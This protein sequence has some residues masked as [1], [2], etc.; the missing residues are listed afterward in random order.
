MS[1]AITI[2]LTRHI[3]AEGFGIY[4]YA[5]SVLAIASVPMGR[6][7]GLMIIRNA[8]ASIHTKFWN[9]PIG[10]AKFSKWPA[11]LISFLFIIIAIAIEYKAGFLKSENIAAIVLILLGLVLL[12][13]QMSAIRVALIRSFEKPELAQITDQ[14]AKPF[15]III[16]LIL[17]LNFMPDSLNVSHVF[18]ILT[19]AACL[20]Y[21]IGHL[22]MQILSPASL[23]SATASSLNKDWIKKSLLLAGGPALIVVNA[24]TDILML[25]VFLEPKDIGIYKVAAQVAIFAGV[26]YTALNFIAA[27]KISL[28]KEQGEKK[29]LQKY[30]TLLSRLAVLTVIP[31]PLILYFFGAPLIHFVFGSEFSAALAPM[32]ILAMLQLI[33]ASFGMCN[34][35]LV[36]HGYEKLIIRYTAICLI[37]NIVLCI[38][39]IPDYGIVG[40][41]FSNLIATTLWNFLLWLTV[42]RKVKVDTGVIGLKS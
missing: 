41:A 42:F 23:K 32:I 14:L 22:M 18:I 26:G 12:F 13:D 11:L 9:E 15:L 28:L 38:L 36:M 39:L 16:G 6:G 20:N 29:V 27:Q 31:A 30:V 2:L 24:Y 25:G 19:I 1:M 8:S 7:W 17:S 10:M 5:V 4:A 33:S 21:I 35:M 34:M 37:F 40:A 3:G